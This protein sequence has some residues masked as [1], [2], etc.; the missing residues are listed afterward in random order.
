MRIQQSRLLPFEIAWGTDRGLRR[1]HRPNEDQVWV[2]VQGGQHRPPLLLVA[3]GMGGHKGGALASQTAVQ[4]FSQCFE[5][6]SGH[7]PSDWKILLHQC[8]VA[9]HEQIVEQAQAHAFPQMGSTVV[10]SLLF[11]HQ[12]VGANVGD[13]RAYLWHRGN[14]IRVSRDHS[15]VERLV[16]QGELTPLEALRHPKR[17]RLTQALSA[18][19]AAI[20]PY[21]FQHPW[22]PG[23]VLLLCSDGL[24]E[25][26]PDS[27]MRAIVSQK[28]VPQAVEHLI[29]LANR[30]GGPDNISVVVARYLS[31]D[32]SPPTMAFSDASPASTAGP[33]DA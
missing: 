6:V 12:V 24:W 25:V 16:Q 9:A 27:V 21:F 13:S 7:W 22:E 33:E 20:T 3:D 2:S 5:E 31:E 8:I 18:H 19:R 10:V 30:L 4:A 1:R 14:W 17:S 26:V 11:P 15:V 29:R 23:D 32:S 28:A